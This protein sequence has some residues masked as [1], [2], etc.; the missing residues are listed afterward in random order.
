MSVYILGISCYYHDSA[1]V[2]LLDGEIVAAMQEERFTRKKNDP[3]FPRYSINFCLNKAGICIT[4]ISSVVFY[5]KPLLKFERILDTYLQFSPRGFISFSKA[6]P[7]WVKDKIFIKENLQRE[8]E[9]FSKKFD[10]K[11]KLLFSE[12]HLSHAASSFFSSPYERAAILTLDGVGEWATTSLALGDKNNINI[13]KEINFPHSL[14]LLYS[15]FTYYVGFRVNSGEYKLMGLAPYGMPIYA[16][17][18]KSNLIDIKEDGS[19]RLNLEF[20]DFCTGL[21]MISRKFCDLFNGK[22][23]EPTE[24]IT[25][26]HMDLAAS[27]QVVTEEILLK[28]TKYVK[29]ETQE[30][31]LCLA[32]GVALN[33]V[34]NGKLLR[35]SGFKNM[36]I[37]PASGDSGGALGAALVAHHIFMKKNRNINKKYMGGAYFGTSYD[38][39]EIEKY[40][41]DSGAIFEICTEE[42]LINRCAYELSSG[43]AI[44]WFQGRM[45][46]GPRALGARSILADP[47]S[48]LMQKNL[49][50]KVKYRES[51]RPF[52]PAVLSEFASEWFDINVESPY[53]LFTA[54]VK[55]NKRLVISEKENSNFGFNKLGVPRSLIPAVTHVDYSARIQTVSKDYNPMF[56][57]LMSCFN[58]ITGCPILVNTSFNIRSEPIVESPFDAFRCFM[59]T[60]L[61]ILA[62]GNC[63]LRKESQNAHLKKNYMDSLEPD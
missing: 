21:E 3:S 11:D 47:R 23:R 57:K 13:I 30:D 37:Q 20:F 36:W 16:D 53:M 4:D 45:E 15:A 62:I 2:L 63:F 10:I 46:F 39:N 61:D 48:P 24:P 43:K 14:G 51:F 35:N 44:G 1:A 28:L 29:A 9:K 52:A 60:D 8:L 25:Q 56:Y 12:H 50:M 19:F 59:N 32:G 33:C 55:E 22:S 6:I 26:K 31:N 42:D 58:Q 5:D 27:I 34:A 54:Q 49:N 40:L 7:T 17:L 38:Q 18:I 41:L